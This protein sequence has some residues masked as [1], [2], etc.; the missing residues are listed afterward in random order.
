MKSSTPDSAAIAPAVS[1]LSP[2][3]MTVRMPILRNCAKRSL[4]PPL[5]MSLSSMTPSVCRSSATTSGV[6]P[7]RETSST[8][9]V[10]ACGNTPPAGFDKTLNRLRRAFANAD[11]R[12]RS[13]RVK[14]DAAHA[15]LRRERHERRLQLVHFARAQSEFF[16]RQHDDAAAFRRFI[17]ER[18]ELRRARQ[19]TFFNARRDDETRPPCDCPA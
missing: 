7:R 2:V 16:F 1:G 4:I 15:R 3:I 12:P 6:A 10:T 8:A 9:F 5:T 17:G 18:A 11:R 19:I 13:V 14:I